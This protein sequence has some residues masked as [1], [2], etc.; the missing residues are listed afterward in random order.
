MHHIKAYALMA[1]ST[2]DIEG[3]QDF[4]VASTAATAITANT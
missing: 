3:H 4:I 2:L 1:M